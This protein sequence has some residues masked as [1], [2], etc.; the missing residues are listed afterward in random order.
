MSH[1]TEKL[2]AAE[3]AS[4]LV[5]DGMLVG[6]GTGSTVAHF[7][8]ALAR[9]DLDVRCVASS[10][11]TDAAARALGLHVVD[12]REIERLDIAV[13]GA[14][15]I[16]PTR[17]LIKGRGGAHTR[18]KTLAAAAKRFVVIADSTKLVDELHP[19]VPLEILAFALTSTLRQLAPTR[20][21]DEALSPDGG[22]LAD[23]LG[24]IEQPDVTA[25]WLASTPGVISHGLFAPSLVTDILVGRGSRVDHVRAV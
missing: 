22:V 24:P 18:E 14:D 17:W 8:T 4:E 7:L 5:H 9:R 10:P 6:L 19:P 12:F 13:D 23:Y 15:Q 20:V 25:T 11:R 3:A 2:H 21:R 1:E 16:A